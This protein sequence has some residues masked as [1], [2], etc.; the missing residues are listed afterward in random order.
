MTKMQRFA[1]QHF[2]RFAG[3]T[4]TGSGD[5]GTVYAIEYGELRNVYASEACNYSYRE[6]WF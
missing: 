6:F 2:A 5:Y 3:A 4:Y 1:R